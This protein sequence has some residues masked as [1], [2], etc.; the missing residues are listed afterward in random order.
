LSRLN[1]LHHPLELLHLLGWGATAPEADNPSLGASFFKGLRNKPQPLF[2][3]VSFRD[4]IIF[5]DF[6]IKNNAIQNQG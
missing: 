4:R 1:P 5:A 2:L 6:S 3:F